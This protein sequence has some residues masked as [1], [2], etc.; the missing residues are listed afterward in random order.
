MYTTKKVIF[1][2]MFNYKL[3][4]KLNRKVFLPWVR[5]VKAQK[6]KSLNHKIKQMDYDEMYVTKLEPKANIYSLLP[7]NDWIIFWYFL[8]HNLRKRS[9]RVIPE[10]E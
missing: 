1:Q 6:N 10:M 5:K 3:L 2:L 9:A 4:G 8:R 7:Q